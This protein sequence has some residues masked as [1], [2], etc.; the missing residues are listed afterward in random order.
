MSKY[1]ALTR[2][3]CAAVLVLIATPLI[4]TPA[5]AAPSTTASSADTTSN[6]RACLFLAP[7]G[8]GYAGHTGW[9]VLGTGTWYGGATEQESNS[10]TTG[11]ASWIKGAR[12]MAELINLFKHQP[13]RGDRPYTKYRCKNVAHADAA[14]ATVKFKQLAR[15][16]YNFY[17]NN[18]LTRS[19]ETF[20]A[21]SPDL[22]G[23]YRGANTP[24]TLYY[25]GTGL[26]GFEESHDI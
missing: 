11:N 16:K 1:R 7:A 22:N 3:M 4:A 5:D 17:N 20:W 18:C 15:T 23:L 19:I 10:P 24:P 21:Y 12:N 6:G 9:A 25:T 26:A 2:K 14:A 13:Q 8:A